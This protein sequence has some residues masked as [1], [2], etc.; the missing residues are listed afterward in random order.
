M[1]AALSNARPASADDAIL[2]VLPK[3]VVTPE[4]VEEAASDLAEAARA[5]SRVA[6]VG[7]GTAL[8]LGSRPHGLN[9]VLTTEKLGRLV[10]HVPSDQVITVEAGM[11][12]D[13]FQRAVAASGQRLALD[14][15]LPE[16]ATL[17]GLLATNGFGP[18][19]TRYGTLRDLLLGVTIVRA[20]GTPARSGSKVVKNVAGFDLP[21]MM[22]GS[23]GTLGLIA[24]AT[25]R[26]HPLPE[27]TATLLLPGRTPKEIRALVLALRDAQLEPAAAAAL[28]SGGGFDLGLRY[29]GFEAGVVEQV[30]RTQALAA[31]AGATCDALD[32]AA[33]KSFWE[34]HDAVRTAGPLRA[35]VSMLP[36]ALGDF[37]ERVWAPGLGSFRGAACV[38]YPTL[39]ILFSSLSA[40]DSADE[41][42]AARAIASARTALAAGG[43]TLV[44]EEAPPG[45]RAHVDVWG[46]APAGIALMRRLKER[47]DPDALLNPGRFTGGI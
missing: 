45:V 11:T 29:E 39:G 9:L 36:A 38:V 25:F 43:G 20:D 41:L 31:K 34:K 33:A 47:L 19:R 3:E 18:L 10:E 16:R 46:P 26:L 23:L 37:L 1:T 17:G 35:K 15:P 44:L 27:R 28:L 8:S 5:R 32:D 2:G 40:L 24:T 21:K 4:T 6:F 14:A 12:L 42:E 30:E 22:V 13:A 7:G